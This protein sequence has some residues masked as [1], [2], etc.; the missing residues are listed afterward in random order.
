MKGAVAAA[1]PGEGPGNKLHSL[2]AVQAGTP[3]LAIQTFLNALLSRV[4]GL[5]QIIVTDRDGVP[6][7]RS[8]QQPTEMGDPRLDTSLIT[9]CA[10]TCEQT[11]KVK[12]LGKMNHILSFY[13]EGII[14]QV[15]VAPLIV[16]FHADLATNTGELLEMIPSC[17]AALEGVRQLVLARQIQEQD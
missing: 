10:T 17:R 5:Q 3:Q 2:S 6:I 13:E 14:L 7:L 1:I 16:T 4:T 15:N 8:R 9:V 11:E 12:A